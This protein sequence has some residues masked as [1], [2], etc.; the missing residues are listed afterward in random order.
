[1][2]A[3]LLLQH[4]ERISEAPNAIGRLR[5]FILDL[6]VRGKLVAQDANDEP[7]AELLKRIY[8]RKATTK[9]V[10]LKTERQGL[11]FELPSGWCSASFGDVFSLEY[12]DSLPAEKRSNSGEFPVYGSNGVVGSHSECLVRSPCIVIGRKG[13]AGALNLSLAEGC[14]VTDVAY[15]CVP[16]KE[17]DLLFALKMFHTLRLENLGKGVKPGLSR[18]D[19]YALPIAIPPIAEQRR[20]TAKVDELMGL[21]DQFAA[22][23][24]EREESRG[25]LVAASLQRLNQPDDE[26]FL[27]EP[28]EFVLGNLA[29]LTTRAEYIKQLRQTILNLAIRGKLVRQL[30]DE[31]PA[32]LPKPRAVSAASGMDDR[33]FQQFRH[34]IALPAGWQIAPLLQ[35]SEHIVDCPHSTPKWTEQG[36]ICV[37]TNQLRP[38]RLD[39]SA[40]RFVSHETYR[41]RIERLEPRAGDILYSREGGILGIASEIPQGVRLCLGQRL[42]LIRPCSQIRSAYLDVVLNSPFITGIAGALTIGGAAPRV[43]MSTVRAYPIPVPPLAEQERIVLK[44]DVLMAL[45]DRLEEQL[46]TRENDSGHLLEALLHEALMISATAEE[47]VV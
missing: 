25:R 39:L 1:M 7:A 45:C 43:N 32:R 42:M 9:K 12:G 35:I 2:S 13:S 36:E 10:A 21:C 27:N 33:V 20:I 46:A 6:A 11:M 34:S 5:R 16:P 31:E 29:R 40:P 47:A 8:A 38:R 30:K 15:Y 26:K 28:V 23:K 44:V 19:A 3:E 4:F 18:S 41:E 37:R 17:I 22:A 14:W 24:A